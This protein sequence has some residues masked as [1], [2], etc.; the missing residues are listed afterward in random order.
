MSPNL[1]EG[2]NGYALLHNAAGRVGGMDIGF[3]PHD[4]GGVCVNGDMNSTNILTGAVITGNV[5]GRYG[6]GI[7]C[8]HNPWGTLSFEGSVVA[9]NTPTEHENCAS[10]A[11]TISSTGAGTS[12]SAAC[13]S[14][15]DSSNTAALRANTRNASVSSGPA[16]R[17]S[18]QRL[19]DG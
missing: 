15:P 4:G 6:G 9:G 8:N 16:S 12:S 14:P 19:I 10:T 1:A 2:W 17:S 5:A 13:S 3:V 7:Y 18:D 11:W